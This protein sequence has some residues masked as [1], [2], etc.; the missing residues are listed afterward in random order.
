MTILFAIP[1]TLIALFESQLDTSKNKTMRA[2][3]EATED[4]QEDDPACQDPNS[5]D[6]P[7]GT[8]SIVKFEDLVQ[9]FPNTAAVSDA[10]FPPKAMADVLAE[11]RGDAHA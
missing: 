3:L 11:C 5:D 1:L 10:F 7:Q 2:W 6:D 9:A 4:G 8:I